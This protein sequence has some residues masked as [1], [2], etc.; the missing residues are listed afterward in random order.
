MP[1]FVCTRKTAG[2]RDGLAEVCDRHFGAAQLPQDH[3]E[4]IVHRDRIGPDLQSTP[5]RYDRLLAP[6]HLLKGQ[7]QGV[8]GVGIVRVQLQ[9]DPA[10]SGRPHSVPQVRNA[11]PRSIWSAGT[12]GRNAT[13]RPK[14]RQRL[15]TRHARRAR[16][17]AACKAVAVSGSES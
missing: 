5:E 13:G 12:L 2:K 11:S 7:A 16:H 8:Q 6:A 14:N 1:R 3:A 10:A 17:R 15:N 4:I 9:R